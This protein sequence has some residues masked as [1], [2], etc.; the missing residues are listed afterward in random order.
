MNSLQRPLLRIVLFPEPVAR[1][2]GRHERARDR[3]RRQPGRPADGQQRAGGELDRAVDPDG[4]LGSFGTI[5]ETPA[6]DCTMGSACF[7]TRSGRRMVSKPWMMKID[8]ISGRPTA[9]E[10]LT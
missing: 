7:A 9:L 10:Y 5:S 4:L 6:S 8:A 2:R 1:R 3:Q